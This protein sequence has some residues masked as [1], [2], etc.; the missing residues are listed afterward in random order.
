MQDERRSA[1]TNGISENGGNYTSQG[2]EETKET[3]SW[4]FTPSDIYIPDREFGLD[5]NAAGSSST[6]VIQGKKT[7]SYSIILLTGPL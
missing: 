3:G 6:H 7:D 4:A 2:W 1:A 5:P